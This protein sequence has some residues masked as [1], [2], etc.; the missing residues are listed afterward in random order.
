MK[1]HNLACYSIIAVQK[2]NVKE[3]IYVH[4]AEIITGLHRIIDIFDS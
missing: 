1:T 4:Y 2:V 3:K